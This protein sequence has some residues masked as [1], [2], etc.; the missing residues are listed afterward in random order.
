MPRRAAD[1]W[2]QRALANHKQGSLHRSLGVSLGTKLPLE[3][4][5]EAAE[6]PERFMKTEAAQRKLARRATLA[7][8]LRSFRRKKRAG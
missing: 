4:L 5:H 7:I 6:H 8:T 1:R 3:R 2:I